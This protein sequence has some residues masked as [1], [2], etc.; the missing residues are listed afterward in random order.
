M[1]LE[2]AP[3]PGW[4]PD[5][6]R[7]QRLRWWE[8]TDWSDARRPAQ[9]TAE[10]ESAERAEEQGAPTAPGFATPEVARLRRDDTDQ[11]ISQVRDAARGE[12]DRASELLSQRLG[13]SIEQGRSI[14]AG[15]MDP[16]LRL[17]K[18]AIVTAAILVIAWFVIQ[19]I[20]QAALLSWV[21]D[22]IDNLTGG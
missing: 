12:V 9:T 17:M 14:V 19:F 10:V 3:P 21:G 15:Y 13:A 8:G 22:R 1:K 18:V 7:G 11:I 20:S 6:E 5:P 4:Y 2:D 16:V